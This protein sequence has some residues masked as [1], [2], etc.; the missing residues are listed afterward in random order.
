MKYT[1]LKKLLLFIIL[2]LSFQTEGLAAL[3]NL[4]GALYTDSISGEFIFLRKKSNT[5]SVTATAPDTFRLSYFGK[6]RRSEFYALLK[7]GKTIDSAYVD[8][9]VFLDSLADSK[10]QVGEQ[11]EFTNSYL[12]AIIWSPKTSRYSAKAN[13]TDTL[14]LKKKFTVGNCSIDT[15]RISYVNFAENASIYS[16]YI[17]TYFGITDFRFGSGFGLY[18]MS[19]D[20]IIHD[21]HFQRGLFSKNTELNITTEYSVRLETVNFSGKTNIIFN[22][23]SSGESLALPHNFEGSNFFMVRGSFSGHTEFSGDLSKFKF[24]N[25]AIHDTISL[26]SVLLPEDSLYNS[27]VDALSSISFPG[28]AQSDIYI[29]LYPSEHTAALSFRPAS[30]RK[31]IPIYRVLPGM[32]EL[33]WHDVDDALEATIIKIE[34][35]KDWLQ[36]DK[37]DISQ[38]FRYF[39]NQYRKIHLGQNMKS[40]SDG[41]EYGWLVITGA[42]VNHGYRGLGKFSCWSIGMILG[43]AMIFMLRYRYTITNHVNTGEFS[44]YDFTPVKADK[45][46]ATIAFLA[47]L[48]RCLWFSFVVFVNPRMPSTYF[49]FS[50][51]LITILF[52]EWAIGLFFLY[53][54]IVYILSRYSFVKAFLAL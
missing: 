33:S 15:F 17:K 42:L 47:D 23:Y 13:N 48:F 46:N 29:Q 16:C 40:V 4:Y 10:N 1:Q 28:E 26:S 19:M 24:R 54:F 5:S 20:G 37:D 31:M 50:N 18:S 51:G 6:S 38:R 9:P 52:A 44:P 41:F 45:H 22:D 34:S 35:K 43:F 7:K 8:F 21:L 36:E 3:K 39:R 30:V 49:R 14:T 2:L 11:I 32:G 27:A 53:L 12:K 25:V